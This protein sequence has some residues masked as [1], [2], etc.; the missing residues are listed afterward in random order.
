MA[1]ADLTLMANY[2]KRSRHHVYTHGHAANSTPQPGKSRFFPREGGQK[3]TNEVIAAS[4]P[5]IVQPDGRLRYEVL[6]LGRVVGYDR[7]GSP[8]ARGGVV[9]VEGLI[10]PPYS[11][12]AANEVVT[13]Y[14]W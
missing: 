7:Y 4:S 14:P 8:T 2:T 12:F 1:T 11:I 6:D 3:F 9:V 10:P 5:P 13:Q